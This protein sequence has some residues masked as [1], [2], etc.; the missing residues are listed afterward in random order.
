MSEFA[1]VY[2]NI[3]H[4]F[5]FQILPLNKKKSTSSLQNEQGL[6]QCR[7]NYEYNRRTFAAW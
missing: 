5:S 1:V 6:K 7:F 2:I 4:P 3:Q